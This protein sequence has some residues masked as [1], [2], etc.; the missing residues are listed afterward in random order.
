MNRYTKAIK[1]L[2]PKHEA[3]D[4]LETHRA[5][6]LI[7][8]MTT[9]NVFINTVPASG[10]DTDLVEVD[11]DNANV[12]VAS[13]DQTDGGTDYA[14]MIG[15]EIKSSGS[16]TGQDGG[17]NVGTHLAFDGV[18]GDGYY[19]RWATLAAVDSTN[20]DEMVITAIRGNDTNGGEDPDEANEELEVWYQ[21]PGTTTQDRFLPMDYKNDGVTQD[22]SYSSTIIP[23]GSGSGELREW[24]LRIPSWARAANTKFMLYQLTSSGKGWDNY[25][26]TKVAYRRVTPISVVASLDSPEASSFIRV[27]SDPGKP[28]SPKKR[29][30]KVNDMLKASAQY[31]D[32]KFGK[33]FPGSKADPVGTESR[34]TLAKEKAEKDLQKEIGAGK[35][36]LSTFQK[37]KEATTQSVAQQKKIQQ[38]KTSQNEKSRI[39]QNLSKVVPELEGKEV[40]NI[41]SAF[42]ELASVDN[43]K[44]SKDEQE[45]IDRIDKDWDA[46]E[47]FTDKVVQD[48]GNYKVNIAKSIIM[49][50]PIHVDPDSISQKDKLSYIKNIDLNNIGALQLDGYGIPLV[51]T[52]LNYSDA[53]I[54][55]DNNGK[56]HTNDGSQPDYTAGGMYDKR[57]DNWFNAAI[58]QHD[59]PLAARGKAQVQI[60]VP[61]DGSPPYLRYTDH[62]YQNRDSHG[63]DE[64]PNPVIGWISDRVD[65]LGNL[66]HRKGDSD[67]DNTDAM[68]GYPKNLRGDVVTQF[69]I[70]LSE[71]PQEFQDQFRNVRNNLGVLNSKGELVPPDLPKEWKKNLP[72]WF[73]YSHR[74]EYG[75]IWGHNYSGG[76]GV[77]SPSSG[78]AKGETYTGQPE[79]GYG[80]PG[81]NYETR[82]GGTPWTH[83]LQKDVVDPSTVQQRHDNFAKRF[84]DQAPVETTTDEYGRVWEKQPEVV[85]DKGEVVAPEGETDVTPGETLSDDDIKSLEKMGLTPDQIKRVMDAGGVKDLKDMASGDVQAYEYKDVQTQSDVDWSDPK[86]VDYYMNNVFDDKPVPHDDTLLKLMLAAT[87][88]GKVLNALGGVINAV[89]KWWNQGKTFGPK[90]EEGWSWSKLFQDD[91]L[92]RQM[93]S[94]GKGDWNP[95][96]S[97]YTWAADKGGMLSGPTPMVR[98]FFRRLGPTGAQLLEKIKNVGFDENIKPTIEKMSDS[99][100]DTRVNEIWEQDPEGVE[101]IYTPLMDKDPTFQKYDALWAEEDKMWTD[102][103][104]YGQDEYNLEWKLYRAQQEIGKEYYGVTSNWDDTVPGWQGTHDNKGYADSMLGRLDVARQELRDF[105]HQ[106]AVWKG[107]KLI[108]GGG[109]WDEKTQWDR[110]PYSY[111][112]WKSIE[113]AADDAFPVN[114]QGDGKPILMKDAKDKSFVNYYNRVKSAFGIDPDSNLAGRKVPSPVNDVI[115]QWNSMWRRYNQLEQSRRNEFDKLVSWN[116][117]EES[118]LQGEVDRLDREAEDYRLTYMEPLWDA[119]SRARELEKEIADLDVESVMDKIDREVLIQWERDHLEDAWTKDGKYK[120]EEYKIASADTDAYWDKLIKALEAQTPVKSEKDV[121]DP[122]PGHGR[123]RGMGDR[124]SILKTPKQKEQEKQERE[125][126]VTGADAATVASEKRKRRKNLTA[127]YHSRGNIISEKNYYEPHSQVHKLKAPKVLFRYPGKP[128]PD[129]FPDNPPPKQVNGWHPEYGK[130]ANRFDKLDPISAKAMPKQGDPEIDAKVAAAKKKRVKLVL[131]KKNPAVP[132]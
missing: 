108:S 65:D 70:P 95:F 75:R 8:D 49:N 15:T 17:F 85:N 82:T 12:F 63:T 107:D 2:Q 69:D 103:A 56:V 66:F 106:P 38:V 94:P 31:T 62:A 78:L 98:E 21:I 79:S 28:S 35:K 64:K 43:H 39:T 83:T 30:K 123:G 72:S 130:R 104:Q 4:W 5:R 131:R 27:G 52:P 97:L 86:M 124:G 9:G 48:I 20:F 114:Y 71:L 37:D 100:L 117:K 99:K 36:T 51:S 32:K 13:Q 60:V 101:K 109:S 3:K 53:N 90:G 77:L 59:N 61:E 121:G 115:S 88:G 111:E 68:K 112:K 122:Y 73:T 7:E 25:G 54:Y 84:K 120:D 50:K 11:T 93:S 129:G 127:S 46:T 33:D 26:I 1:T 57:F 55:V 89:G 6:K 45:L 23:V 128:S 96:R 126:G 10:E 116:R 125:W 24:K 92:K 22:T 105:T 41:S 18:D 14:A 132:K 19:Y 29:K 81:F 118:R 40:K 102:Y 74:D 91:W 34:G 113:K 110:S 119:Q 67:A 16:G 44:L 80:T 58:A 47:P 76:L 42:K 87:K